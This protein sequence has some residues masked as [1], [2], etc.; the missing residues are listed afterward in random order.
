MA[1]SKPTVVVTGI[2]G[3][4]GT[5]LLPLLDGFEVSGLDARP[6]VEAS[7]LA[8][9]ERLDLALESSCGQIAHLLRE[10][11]AS[12]VVHLAFV[13]DPLK[14]G[15]PDR[16]R[17]WRINVAGTARVLEA[18][19]EA[20][21]MDGAVRKFVHLSSVSVYG[22]NL[23]KPARE[24]A[25]LG[26]HT[27]NYAVQ[28][29]E[30]DLAVQARAESL[31]DCEVWILRPHIFS[32]ASVQNYMIDCLRGTAYGNGRLGRL[33]RKRGTRLP[34]VL[35]MGREYLEHRL[36]FAHVD[37][38]ARVA[39]WT[40]RATPQPGRV[41]VVNVAG[42]GPELTVAQCAEIAQA[43][44]TRLPTEALCRRVIASMWTAGATAIPPDSFPY[45]IGSYTMD[46]MKLQRLLGGE[47]EH[48]VRFT[49]EQALAAA[50]ESREASAQV[51]NAP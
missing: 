8:R 20:N 49:N 15:V 6:P 24:D 18:I 44:I 35:P 30:A 27:L 38:V 39:A 42:S 5:S 7:R 51:Q 26:A 48:V 41:E 2:S 29:K 36:Q 31:G 25:P 34:L 43:G 37:D 13:L 9:F 45:L 28:K 4:L 12:A 14:Y 11:R 1:S 16:E 40:L 19:A 10:T 17:M 46:T 47:Y 32:G 3:N 21:R 23:K 33:L 50:F 22:P